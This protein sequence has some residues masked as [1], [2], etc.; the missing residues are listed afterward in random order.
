MASTKSDFIFRYVDTVPVTGFAQ[1]STVSS[2]SVG[3]AAPTLVPVS[4]PGTPA[5]CVWQQGWQLG[6]ESKHSHYFT[7]PTASKPLPYPPLI[8]QVGAPRP[9]AWAMCRP[10]VLHWPRSASTK[11][12]GK[13]DC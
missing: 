13:W 11:C 12:R 4:V 9:G 2:S 10:S 6:G 8:R 5:A 3:A 1:I 7:A